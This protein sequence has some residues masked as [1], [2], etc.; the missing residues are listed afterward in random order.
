MSIIN[1]TV[2]DIRGIYR[3][4]PCKVRLKALKR[5]VVGYVHSNSTELFHTEINITLIKAVTHK[6]N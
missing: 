6:N 5:K 1:P 3:Y 4:K 2:V